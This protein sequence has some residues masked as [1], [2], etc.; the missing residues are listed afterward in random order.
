MSV[1]VP[2]ML[3][4]ER[5]LE[6]QPLT[7]RRAAQEASAAAERLPRYGDR[8]AIIGCGTSFFIAQAMA[9]LREAAGHGETDAYAASE[10][11]L[12][13]PYDAV[14]AV[15]RSG[16][17]TEVLNALGRVPDAVP[18][19]AIS[20]VSD[21]PL[22]AVVEHMVLLDFADESSVVQTRFATGALALFRAL[23]HEPV[24]E[25]SD[26][27]EAALQEPIPVTLE[28]FNQIVFLATGWGVGVANEAALKLREAA[29]AW[30]EA[31]PAMEYRHGPISAVTSKTL[32]WAL[33]AVDE[34]VL[35]DAEAAG[36][37]VIDN[38]R[39]P[40]VELVTIHRAAV[41]LANARGLD[42]DQPRFL[43]RSVVLQ[44]MPDPAGEGS[45]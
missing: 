4:I 1:S 38:Q 30:T 10:A 15:S 19:M 20:A 43:S 33:G 9:G 6:S 42:P 41:A 17:T 7:W 3:K 13:R 44:T 21:S 28:A 40:M 26:A 12:S 24:D 2:Q 29:G 8:L 32:V 36:A 18:R 39:D 34:T 16:T 14:L 23:L 35:G 37:T 11:L 22:T 27:A 25:L 45:G 5:E 31:Y